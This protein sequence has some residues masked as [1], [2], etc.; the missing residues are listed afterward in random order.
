MV[1]VGFA[2]LFVKLN[3]GWAIE[4]NY[5][6]IIFDSPGLTFDYFGKTAYAARKIRQAM[7]SLIPI[8]NPP[9]PGAL[10][11]GLLWLAGS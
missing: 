8:T 9:L 6:S 11:S 2:Y 5:A 4:W 1:I 7:P 10:L 3:H